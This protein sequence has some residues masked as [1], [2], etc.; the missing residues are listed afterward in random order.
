[1]AGACQ[2]NH[3]VTWETRPGR[4]RKRLLPMGMHIV[5][6][7]RSNPELELHTALP[8]GDRFGLVRLSDQIKALPPGLG[9][10]LA[11]INGDYYCRGGPYAGDPQGLQIMRGELV[12]GPCDWTC[13]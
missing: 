6:V 3:H 13:F 10:P 4:R 2:K 11:A 1:G 9:R 5:K 8:K 12:S 7:D